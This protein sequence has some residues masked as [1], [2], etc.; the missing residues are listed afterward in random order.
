MMSGLT[1]TKYQRNQSRA[2]EHDATE[3]SA[4]GQGDQLLGDQLFVQ[5]NLA[6]IRN[7]STAHHKNRNTNHSDRTELMDTKK[8]PISRKPCTNDGM[9][10][11]RILNSMRK[12]P[13]PINAVL[14]LFSMDSY[15]FELLALQAIQDTATV[16]DIFDHLS[17]CQ[18]ECLQHQ[19]Y[20]GIL[21]AS[22]DS[23]LTMNKAVAK[24]CRGNSR[25]SVLVAVPQGASIVASTRNAVRLLSDPVIVGNLEFHG[26]DASGW[27]ARRKKR[28]LFSRF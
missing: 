12:S 1:V 17:S 15:R 21:S 24:Y 20:Q 23:L 28:I 27:T 16:A 13:Q 6:P 9:F 14:L 19:K 10:M 25:N 22:S 7:K 4:S 2:L 26:F 5:E 11:K 3:I 18:E 8:A